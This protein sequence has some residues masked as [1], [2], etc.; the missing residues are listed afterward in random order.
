MP[1]SRP[2]KN[3][4][5]KAAMLQVITTAAVFYVVVLVLMTVLQRNF[6]YYPESHLPT[7]AQSGVASMDEV[8]FSTADGLELLAWS[9]PPAEV[10]KPWVVLFHG[11]AGTIAGRAFKARV[12]LDAGYGVLLVE[13]RGYGGNPGS[14]TE[15]GLFADGRAALAYLGKQGVSGSQ[16]VLY[17]ESL[18]TGVAVAMAS[19]AAEKGQPVAAVLLE[20]PFTS[21]AATAAHH[22]PFLP[23]RLLMKDHFDSLSR[24]GSIQAPLF[25]VHGENDDTVPQVLGRK[26][27]AAAVEPKDALWLVGAGHNDL[28]GHDTAVV[29]LMY[30]KEHNI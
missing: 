13:Y 18:G 24:I 5:T 19:E 15:E 14:P 30:L 20:A 1:R 26:L 17:G 23:V 4:G 29:L 6:L 12:F 2:A 3:K 16:V 10:D 7:R 9:Q 28:F 11:N 25:I 8:R 21:A 22:Y 27:F